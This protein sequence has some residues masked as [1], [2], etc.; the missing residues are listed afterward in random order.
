MRRKWGIASSVVP[1]VF[2]FSSPRP[3]RS[4]AIRRQLRRELGMSESGLLVVQPTRVVPRKGIELA[5]ELVGRLRDRHA[6]LLITSPAGDEGLDYLVELG[7]HAHSGG[8]SRSRI[9]VI[10]I[11]RSTDSS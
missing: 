8:A 3:R 4:P 9:S 6:V 11:P 7:G 10:L 5:I 2:D 1:N